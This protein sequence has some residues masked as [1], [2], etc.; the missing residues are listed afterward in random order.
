MA[1][2]RGDIDQSIVNKFVLK[3]AVEH[4]IKM[5]S[6]KAFISER[7]VYDLIRGFFKKFINIDYE[8]TAE[9]LIKE[10]RKI[11]VPPQSQEQVVRIMKTV[12]E[13]EH[14]SRSFSKEELT[15]LLEDFRGLVESLIVSH[16]EK[17]GLFGKVKDV[18]G[19]SIKDNRKVL[20]QESLLNEDERVYVKMNVLLDNARRWSESD[21]DSAKKAYK[22]LLAL[23]SSIDDEKK[24]TF[25]KPIQELFAL[26][27]SKERR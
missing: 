13:M 6:E 9:E 24:G 10:L 23:Y 5:I 25:F 7:E 3:K 22:E 11:Y 18:I 1:E 4:K 16:Y 21:L 12:S 19:G 26:L 27:N 2:K 14:V 15:K 20:N 8:F 17:H